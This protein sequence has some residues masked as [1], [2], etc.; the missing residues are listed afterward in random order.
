MRR[1]VKYLLTRLLVVIR[2]RNFGFRDSVGIVFDMLFHNI[3]YSSII[4]SVRIG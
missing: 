2:Q 4:M 3:S 1:T